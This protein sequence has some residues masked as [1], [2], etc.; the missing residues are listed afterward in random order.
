VPHPNV[1][2]NV[3]AELLHLDRVFP[4]VPRIA[5]YTGTIDSL[6]NKLVSVWGF[7]A[8]DAYGSCSTD[9]DC[10]RGGNCDT[11]VGVCLIASDELR[12]ATNRSISAITPP[13]FGYL[14]GAELQQALPGDSGGPCFLDGAIVG[15]NK[16]YTASGGYPNSSAVAI[17]AVRDWVLATINK[18]IQQWSRD[19]SD[20]QGWNSAEYYY[21]TIAYT[22]IN[23]DGSADVC[24]RGA[25][26]IW[27][28]LSGPNG[29]GAMTLWN[30]YF[31]NAVGW[32]IAPYYYSTIKFPDLDGDRQ[33][34][35]CGRA[36]D[37]IHCALSNGATGFGNG[38]TASV[39]TT[40]FDNSGNNT[41]PANWTTIDFPDLNGDKKA[42][43]CGRTETGVWCALSNGS[44][45]GAPALWS[46]YFSDVNGWN[47]QPY[48]YGT[49]RF[50]D[51]S[52][53]GKADVCGRASD[54]I[55]CALS[56]GT[57]KF[58]TVST[59]PW[60]S[61]F[62]N[63]NGWNIEED[64]W[65]TIKYADVNGDGKA[66]VCARQVNGVVCAI[67][68][69]RGFSSAVLWDTAFTNAAGFTGP[70]YWTTIS[71]PDVDSDG[72]ADLCGRSAAG[73]Y[74]AFSNASNSNFPVGTNSFINGRIWS[75]S[76]SDANAWGSSPAYYRTLRF[77]DINYDGR[78]EMCGRANPGI[79][80][81]K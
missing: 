31:S 55:H 77:V 26:G 81:T 73:M 33:A 69:G 78:L 17:P 25:D 3:D 7:G 40:L 15:I 41:L 28:G 79:F 56:N 58:G 60:S 54:G 51:V 20:A 9:A 62:S 29:L 48:Y 71:F 6:M 47:S 57:S 2:A 64:Y 74:C 36:S 14:A 23:K 1:A 66:D 49:I 43:V 59:T 13:F 30:S 45:F 72:R 24:G 27:C 75:D 21:G 38:A 18:P 70:S 50:A 32:N 52:G 22:D 53:D 11:R 16:D 65:G 68:T 5:L 67:S 12:Y 63:A 34:D 39:W 37:G 61:Y 8:K 42:D 76:V 19:Y 4:D 46:G 80:C 44:S 10:T 35:V